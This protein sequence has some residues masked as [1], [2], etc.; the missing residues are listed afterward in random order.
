MFLSG[1]RAYQ[2]ARLAD[3]LEGYTQFRDFAPT[4]LHLIEALRTLR[5]IYYAFWLARRADD[6]AFVQAF[7]WFYNDNFWDQHILMLKEQSAAL[8]QPPLVW[9]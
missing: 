1:D 2:T 7:P 3:V 4:E 8:D 5:I 9:N 6:P